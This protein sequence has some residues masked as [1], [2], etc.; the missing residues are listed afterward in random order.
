MLWL[1]ARQE[2]KL[3]LGL[4]VVAYLGL[5]LGS[6]LVKLSKLGLLCKTLYLLTYNI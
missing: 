2:L 4:G 5:A 1:G 3:E 6:M